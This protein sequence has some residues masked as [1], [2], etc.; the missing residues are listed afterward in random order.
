MLLLLSLASSFGFSQDTQKIDSLKNELAITKN[1]TLKLFYLIRIHEAFEESK[2][3]STY[4]YAKNELTLAKKL[5]L[6]LNEALALNGIAYALKNM[7]NF[8]ASLQSYLSA[9][10]ILQDAS[11]EE[12]ILPQ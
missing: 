3:D 10:E 8:P 6:R 2:P 9:N 1:D 4:F 12:N 11:I 7:G 5:D